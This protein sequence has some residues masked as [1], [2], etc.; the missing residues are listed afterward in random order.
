MSLSTSIRINIWRYIHQNVLLQILLIHRII[1]TS[2]HLHSSKNTTMWNIVETIFALLVGIQI[3]DKHN[4]HKKLKTKYYITHY[5]FSV[6]SLIVI[7]Y[8]K[9]KNEIECVR[10]WNT[11]AFRQWQNG[12]NWVH[13]FV[14]KYFFFRSCFDNSA[15]DKYSIFIFV[16]VCES[17]DWLN[18]FTYFLNHFYFLVCNLKILNCVFFCLV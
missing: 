6:V 9:Y 2:H 18:C 5:W 4:H 12:L 10:K 1:M 7:W 3:V 8:G 17:R 16:C 13:H 15:F 11:M 14:C